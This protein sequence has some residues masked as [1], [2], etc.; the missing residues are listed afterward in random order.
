[1]MEKKKTSK[2]KEPSWDEIGKAIGKKMEKRCGEDDC[3]PWKS[4]MKDHVCKH[5]CGGSFYGVGFIGA[6]IS[7]RLRQASGWG[8]LEC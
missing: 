1:M 7:S 5:K 3:M 4:K 8:S 6:Y 2:A